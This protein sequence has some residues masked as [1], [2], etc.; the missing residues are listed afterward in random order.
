MPSTA[1]RLDRQN[2]RCLSS[3][4]ESDAEQLCSLTFIDPMAM[5]EV[6]RWFSVPTMKLYDNTTDAQAKALAHIRLEE[7]M[8]SRKAFSNTDNM[9][10]VTTKKNLWRPKPYDRSQQIHNVHHSGPFSG[11]KSDHVL[12]PKLTKYGFSVN[13]SDNVHTL[14]KN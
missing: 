4:G 12:P 1:R 7:D 6:P 10:S 2:P 8:H 5:I 14:M 9:M 3:Y 13:A 11:W